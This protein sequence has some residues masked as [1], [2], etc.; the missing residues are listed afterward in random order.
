MACHR[1]LPMSVE[2]RTIEQLIAE[3]Y[4]T[5]TCSTECQYEIVR[6]TGEIAERIAHTYKPRI[7]DR[8]RG[9]AVGHVIEQL[10]E[11]VARGRGAEG[12]YDPSRP[13]AGWCY[14]VVERMAIDR[15][16]RKWAS[17][18]KFASADTDGGD[19]W[20]RVPD[21]PKPIPMPAGDRAALAAALL[22]E[23]EQC[24]PRARDRII[25]AVQIGYIESLSDEVIGRWCKEEGVGD[26]VD[27]L[28]AAVG[29]TGRLKLLAEILGMSYEFARQRSSLA[30]KD[31]RKGDFSRLGEEFA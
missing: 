31:L 9:D 27:K 24:L 8:V 20:S 17:K 12:A 29:E 1:D 10:I 15:Y 21:R 2:A 26:A 7:A 3:W 13:F 5:G 14:I 6:Q 16:R 28:R 22:A 4:D 18:E 25:I 19:P 30:M 11:S 23:F